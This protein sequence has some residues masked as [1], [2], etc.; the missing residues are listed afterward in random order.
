LLSKALT[1]K[2]KKQKVNR[3]TCMY[4]SM[5]KDFEKI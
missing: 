5:K 3:Y 1:G 4:C 2:K